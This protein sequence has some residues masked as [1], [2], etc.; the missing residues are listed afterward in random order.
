MAK[1][2]QK[3]EQKSKKSTTDQVRKRGFFRSLTS[4]FFDIPRW[5][6]VKRYVDTNKLL[7]SKVKD[8]FQVAK[9]Q[10]TETFEA[11]MQRLQLTEQD[12]KERAASIT[13]ALTVMLI[14]IGLLCIYGIYLI[15]TGAIAGALVTLAVIA[16][17]SARAFQYSFW[18]FQ[19]KNKTL[20]CSFSSWLK[21]KQAQV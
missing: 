12:L 6:G 2:T 8:S 14:F 10:R 4:T 21:R 20:G 13:R 15:F 18:N 17:S 1:S 19:I 3:L 7:Y 16:L 11:A 5:I 9:A